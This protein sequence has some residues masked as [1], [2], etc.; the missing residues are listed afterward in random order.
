M[1]RRT[2]H[3]GSISIA[4][5][6]VKTIDFMA[7]RRTHLPCVSLEQVSNRIINKVHGILRVIFKISSQ[8]LATIEWK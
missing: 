2:E 7:A 3:A 1:T 5:H 4:L 6:A 8:P